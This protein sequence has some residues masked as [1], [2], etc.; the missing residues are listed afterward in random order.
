MRPRKHDRQLPSCVYLRHGSYFHVVE[1]RWHNLGRD[2]RAALTEYAKRV[3]Q[4]S[5]GM[6]ALIRQALPHLTRN[7][8]PSTAT[9]YTHAANRL[10]DIFAEFSPHDVLPRHI[11]QMRREMAATPNMANRLLTVLRMVFEYALEQELV[12]SNPAVGIKRLAE[13]KRDRL[14]SQAEYAAIYAKSPPRLQVVLDLLRLTG[15][16]VTDVLGIKRA[17][18]QAEGIYFQQRKTSAKLIVRWSPELRQAVERAKALVG[19]VTGMTLL[20]G[21]AGKPVDYRST[22]DQWVKA[23]LAAGVEDA[24]LRDLRPVAATEAKRQG[25]DPTALLGHTSQS[26][27]KRYLRDKQTPVVDGPSFGHVQNKRG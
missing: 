12:D 6:A 14:L 3:S 1:G 23:C 22:H 10:A 8:A 21:R 11:A 7:V 15:Q 13:G 18:L 16:R 4:P 20:Q 5:S 19:T 17:D 9:Q 26:M 24:D 27:T 2:L 25:L